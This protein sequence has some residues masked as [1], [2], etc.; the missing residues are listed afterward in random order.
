VSGVSKQTDAQDGPTERVSP[1]FPRGA[2]VVIGGSGGI[3]AAICASLAR[4]GTDVVLSY[5]DHLEAAERAAAAVR[6]EGREAALHP[7]HVEDP[8]AVGRFFDQ[9]AKAHECIHTVVSATGADIPMRY[10]SKVDPALWREVIDTD[11]NGFFNVVH[12]SLP[13]L[14]A[15]GGGCIVALTSVGLQRWAARDVLSIG[16]KAGIAAL[17]QGV[18]REEGRH[19]IRAN[20]VALGVIEAGLF[21]RLKGQEFDDAWVE[22][23]RENTALKRFGTAE[24]VAD[25]VV[26]LASARASYLTGQTL[27]LDGG[28]HI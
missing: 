14:R 10:I 17:L 20:S 16:P 25:A 19:G 26:F 2:A 4:A 27:V 21:L 18:A 3:G 22:A 11:L 24:E 1:D 28:Y 9:V 15:A 12:A 7:L 6:S 13:H 5:R 8:A 23:A